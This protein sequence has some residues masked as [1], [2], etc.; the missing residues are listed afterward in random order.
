MLDDAIQ[1]AT[2]SIGVVRGR[3]TTDLSETKPASFAEL[4]DLALRCF[5]NNSHRRDP[6]L[7]FFGCSV[8]R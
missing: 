5:K 7:F 4:E 1:V 6:C 3:R 2:Q 8:Y